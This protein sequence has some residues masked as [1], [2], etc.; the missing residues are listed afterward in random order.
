M[1]D[2]FGSD[3]DVYID[4]DNAYPTS[5]L[6]AR[7]Y[8]EKKGSDTCIVR[9]GEFASGE[10]L[11]MGVY[12][13]ESCSYK[14]KTWYA[15]VIDMSEANRKQMR[16]AQY[17]TTIL[18]YKIPRQSGGKFTKSYEIQIE[19]E[20][21]YQPIELFLSLDD[22]FQIIEEKPASHVSKTSIG[23]KFGEK[24]YQWCTNCFIYAIVNIEIED[25]Y[26]LT[27]VARAQNDAFTTTLPS[28][29]MVNPFQ[30]DCFEYFVLKTLEDVRID[31][32]GFNGQAD[33]YIVPWITPTGPDS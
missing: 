30:Q 5:S 3:P 12:C 20:E 10:I 22:T 25:R 26:Y 33:L 17:S 19:P 4:K 27:S 31:V 18:K 28:T 13:A 9:E 21:Q 14:L 1:A 7:W 32:D 29:I 2:S 11:Y 16:F 24:D 8:C 6:N 23:L 15:N